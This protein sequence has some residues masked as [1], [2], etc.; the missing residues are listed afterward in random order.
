MI[1]KENNI[2]VK[3]FIQN[4]HTML[5]FIDVDEDETR[6]SFI[7]YCS[8]RENFYYNYHSHKNI[9][10][11]LTYKKL[12]DLPWHKREC[13]TTR[14]S[15]DVVYND[16]H[17]HN[18][19]IIF[20]EDVIGILSFYTKKISDKKRKLYRNAQSLFSNYYNTIFAGIATKKH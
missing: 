4:I 5:S 3:E 14:E 1:G 12:L 20:D 19:P 13:Y 8:Q 2:K 7:K 18:F 11:T 15:N 16:F 17:I 10:S 6:L 9:E